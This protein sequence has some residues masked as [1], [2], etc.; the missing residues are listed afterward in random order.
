MAHIIQFPE[1]KNF[2]A[3]TIKGE[4]GTGKTMFLKLFMKLFGDCAVEINNVDQIAHHFNSLLQDKLF[5]YGDEAFWSGDVKIRGQLKNLISSMDLNLTLKGKD[6]VKYS[7][8]IRFAFTTNNPW[9]GPVEKGERRWLS[10][11]CAAK[12]RN[13]S[14]YFLAMKHQLEN[15]GYNALMKYLLERD[16]N[17][18]NWRMLV[19]DS[20][21]ED[22]AFTMTRDN[23]LLNFFEDTFEGGVNG[24]ILPFEIKSEG[25]LIV[26][27]LIQEVLR[28]VKA[29]NIKWDV[30]NKS[31]G[32]K[33]KDIFGD[34]LKS[35]PRKIKGNTVRV[36]DLDENKILE[37]IRGYASKN[38]GAVIRN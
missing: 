29:N 10:I 16:L 27:T 6:S 33:M 9:G 30:N 23:P 35:I 11:K 7:N 8:Y 28:Y 15:G 37:A 18:C 3:L 25:C 36:Y 12:R 21:I 13:D 19:T 17:N 14:S 20:M 24:S 32:M 5:V 1:E 4:Q 2:V 34:D 38:L 22:L 26:G 31:V